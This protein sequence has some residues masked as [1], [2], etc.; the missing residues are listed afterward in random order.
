MVYKI[1]KKQIKERKQLSYFR[2]QLA[3]QYLNEEAEKEGWDNFE[4]VPNKDKDKIVRK[5]ANKYPF[6]FTGQQF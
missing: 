5:V 2:L 3:N 4:K 1:P 6:S